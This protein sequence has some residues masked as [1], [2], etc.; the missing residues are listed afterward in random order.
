MSILPKRYADRV[1]RIRVTFGFIL[2]AAF[3]WLSHPTTR[4]LAYGLPI[5]ALGLFLRAW[6]TGRAEKDLTLTDSGPYA[7]VR[8]PLINVSSLAPASLAFAGRSCI[9][10][11]TS[12]AT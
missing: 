10:A 8:N 1:A 11:P 4:S 5:S 6:T 3:I 12:G 7:Y 9:L 2:I